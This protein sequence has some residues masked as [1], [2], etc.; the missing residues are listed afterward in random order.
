MLEITNGLAPAEAVNKFVDIVYDRQKQIARDTCQPVDM[1]FGKGVL[2]STGA[3]NAAFAFMSETTFNNHIG[4]HMA[5]ACSMEA[6]EAPSAQVPVS[7]LLSDEE[8]AQ[9]MEEFENAHGQG[10]LYAL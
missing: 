8:L 9:I 7:D 6:A 2:H 3:S 10:G 4:K 5:K 1:Q